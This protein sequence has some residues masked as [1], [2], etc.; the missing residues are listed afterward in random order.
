[1]AKLTKT[2]TKRHNEA[3]ELLKK[4]VLTDDERIFVLENWNEGAH[5]MNGAAG[6]F[7]TPSGLAADFSID[8][9]GGRRVID[10]CAGIGSL[11]FWLHLRGR[12][13]EIVCVEINP[14]YIA[15]GKKILPEAT[16]IQADVFNLPKDLGTFDLAISNPPFGSTPRRCGAAPRYTG[17]TFEYHVMD[18]AS[19]LAERGAFIIPQN[20][21]PFTFSGARDYRSRVSDGYTKFHEAT[22]I[23][24]EPGCGVDTSFYKDEWHGVSPTVE[25]VCADFEEVKKQRARGTTGD[26]FGLALAA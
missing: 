20:S 23:E 21:A 22:G 11:S 24:L 3:C 7:F 18:I 12:A 17:S 14:D 26:L 6:A 13:S 8:A 16:W 19:D 15:V 9:G 1:M 5:H 10:L 2:E 25:I 4:E